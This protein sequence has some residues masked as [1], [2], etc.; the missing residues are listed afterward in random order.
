[1]KAFEDSSEDALKYAY[2]LLG[3]RDRSEKELS[4]KLA[5]K[6]F[7][8]NVAEQ[9]V[10]HLKDK[11]FIDDRKLAAA[12][13]RNAVD[14]KYL[15]MAGTRVYLVKKGIPDEIVNEVLSEETDYTNTAVRLIEKKVKYLKGD[16]LDIKRK[17]WGMLSRRGFPYDTIRKA[18]T[19]FDLKEEENESL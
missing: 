3:Y 7:S 1:M 14:R 13:K 10:A 9:A 6:G 11:G 17:L 16:D 12:L 2:R 8:G 5:L 19:S 15:S 18:L 4:E